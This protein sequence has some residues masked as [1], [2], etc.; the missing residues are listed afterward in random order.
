MV[1]H[2]VL[3]N[4]VS[5]NECPGIDGLQ[6][7][8]IFYACFM[9]VM[10]TFFFMEQ[11]A[12][13]LSHLAIWCGATSSSLE[14]DDECKKCFGII[15]LFVMKAIF[16]LILL[17]WSVMGGQMVFGFHERCG[18]PIPPPPYSDPDPGSCFCDPTMYWLAFG[19]LIATYPVFLL[20]ILYFILIVALLAYLLYGQLKGDN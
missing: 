15:M 19:T 2:C 7:G 3:H 6:T 13:L 14:V 12:T 11:L 4:A 10:P 16:F 9:L 1:A 20:S 18:S 8:V 17:V 5:A